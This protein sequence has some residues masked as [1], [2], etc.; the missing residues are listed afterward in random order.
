V[1]DSEM[2]RKLLSFAL[3]RIDGMSIV[4]ADDGM[5]GLKQLSQDTFDI[6]IVD[7]NMPIMD[8]LKLIKHIRNDSSY[9]EMPILVVT[10]E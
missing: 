7:I 5:E 6:V 10:T 8:G 2:M 3:S 1:E 9:K 4:E